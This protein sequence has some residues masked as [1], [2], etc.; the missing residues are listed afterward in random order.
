[1]EG[2]TPKG[3]KFFCNMMQTFSTGI[4][5]KKRENIIFN[6]ITA[7]IKGVFDNEIISSNDKER[8][9]LIVFTSSDKTFDIIQQRIE[10][11]FRGERNRFFAALKVVYLFQ[12]RKE[13][14]FVIFE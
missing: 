6:K 10:R 14:E 1:M 4:S 12:N 5:N 13:K 8:F 11:T 3:N 9:E 2:H 7:F